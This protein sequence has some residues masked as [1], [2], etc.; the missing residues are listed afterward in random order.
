MPQLQPLPIMGLGYKWNLGFA[1]PLPMTPRYNK[2]VLVMI[3]HFS[4]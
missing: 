3:E 2:Y 1:G 4:K